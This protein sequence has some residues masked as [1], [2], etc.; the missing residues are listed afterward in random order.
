M[1]AAT[2]SG[3]VILLVVIT[4]EI[5]VQ[6][7]VNMDAASHPGVE[8]LDKHWVEI[9]TFHSVL[10]YINF[11]SLVYDIQHVSFHGEGV[12]EYNGYAGKFKYLTFI[13]QVR[14]RKLP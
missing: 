2:V 8:K 4:L 6:I 1:N 7:F 3:L 5:I 13:S 11:N 9:F 12:F 10:L 14:H